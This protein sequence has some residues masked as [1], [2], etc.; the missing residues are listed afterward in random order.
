MCT[1][2]T[3]SFAT[4]LRQIGLNL[5]DLA[6]GAPVWNVYNSRKALKGAHNSK[7]TEY[8]EEQLEHGPA[9]LAFE[10]ARDFRNEQLL[11]A[12]MYTK[13]YANDGSRYSLE[14][15]AASE[16]GLVF[17]AF[18]AQGDPEK[19]AHELPIPED[20]NRTFVD[21]VAAIDLRG[22]E[23][24]CEDPYL[25]DET[26]TLT[27]GSIGL[28]MAA[29]CELG[30]ET[31]IILCESNCT[32]QAYVNGSTT[33]GRKID[34]FYSQTGWHNGTS[35]LV[36][37]N[38]STATGVV[39]QTSDG[40]LFVDT[41]RGAFGSQQGNART[42]CATEAETITIRCPKWDVRLHNASVARHTVQVAECAAVDVTTCTYGCEQD[43]AYYTAADG[44]GDDGEASVDSTSMGECELCSWCLE[45]VTNPDCPLVDTT[46]ST[47]VTTTT[48]FQEVA[49]RAAAASASNA[50]GTVSFDADVNALAGIGFQIHHTKP[51]KE[52]PCSFHPR[53]TCQDAVLCRYDQAAKAC[54]ETHRLALW[55][56]YPGDRLEPK[57]EWVNLNFDPSSEVHKYDL[58]FSEQISEDASSIWNAMFMID[59]KEV[60]ALYGIPELQV[61][62][63]PLSFIMHAWSSIPATKIPSNDPFNPWRGA[64]IV[65]SAVITPKPTAACRP[66]GAFSDTDSEIRFK[67][68]VGSGPYRQDVVTLKDV[69][70]KEVSISDDAKHK[71]GKGG[72]QKQVGGG[73]RRCSAGTS[74]SSVQ[75]DALQ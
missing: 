9:G 32:S 7:G 49:D 25:V 17:S 68:A 16:P 70:A 74:I 44:G 14:I 13:G 63:I 43:D 56:R 22:V 6:T 34:L 69:H 46:S 73:R 29:T 54:V 12:G 4:K 55:I 2:L 33:M 11:S 20:Q 31:V 42:V 1:Q 5:N 36:N 66:G 65:K 19:G 51:S 64:A 24:V 41:P 52:E 58:S 62:E 60:L 48:I 45:A 67:A 35:T 39:T 47:T 50:N 38:R 72:P 8:S 10:V 37:H 28:A 75:D 61:A 30:D 3:F 53:R 15:Q 59:D 23:D 18:I 71:Q 26:H 27:C 57:T 40:T 21:L